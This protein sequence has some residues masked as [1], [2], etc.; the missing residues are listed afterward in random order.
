MASAA[1]AFDRL[2]A[3]GSLSSAAGMSGSTPPRQAR[4]MRPSWANAPSSTGRSAE[5]SSGAAAPLRRLI[6]ARSSA[7]H[8]DQ[9][10]SC[11]RANSRCLSAP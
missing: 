9:S 11:W 10:P 1:S 6:T 2:W 3:P 4:A 7:F 5:N 8:T